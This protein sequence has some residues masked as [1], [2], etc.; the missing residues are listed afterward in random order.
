[1]STLLTRWHRSI[2]ELSEEQWKNVVGE[3]AI[4][5]Y[6][7]RWL[8]DLEKSGSL[9]AKQGFVPLYLSVWRGDLPIAFAPLYLKF[10]SF[11]EFIFD[12]GFAN[13]ANDLGLA[14]YPKLIGMSPFSP[15]EG[16]RFFVLEGED[17]QG[18]TSFMINS[19][20]ELAHKNNILSCNFLYVDQEWLAH[21][22]TAGCVQWINEH[23]L[24]SSNRHKNFAE[25]LAEFNS[26]QRRNIKRERKAV[27]DA[28]ISVSV[29]TA[30]EIDLTLMKSMHGFYQNHCARWGIW[31]SK[32]L[33]EAFFEALSQ[34]KQRDQVVLFAAFK[35]GSCE[36]LAMSFCITDGHTLWGRFWGSNEE[37]ACL[38]FELCYYSPISWALEHGIKSFDPGA[39][40]M[41]KRRRGFLA[42][43]NFS[44]HRWY[45]TRMDA[46]IRGWLP[47]ANA[48]MLEGIQAA[49]ADVPFRHEIPPLQ[50]S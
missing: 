7:W 38:H 31:G 35:K 24:W 34:P 37:I 12:H 23:S 44:L 32:Y 20:D 21:A 2:E 30:S 46:V 40:G 15:V 41:H 25:Y 18:L 6:Q 17:I 1:M 5:F 48:L 39:G 49:N 16:Y 27:S 45:D 3:D 28:G 4:P 47:K 29:F 43:P 9:S 50:V 8:L 33:S 26:N 13:L 42:K 36:P 10:H 11:G 22:E 19:I 14:Y